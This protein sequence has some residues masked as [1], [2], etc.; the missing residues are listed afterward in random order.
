MHRKQ[1]LHSVFFLC[2]FHTNFYQVNGQNV[3]HS[4]HQQ[5]VQWLVS[6]QGD[7]ELLVQHVPQPAGLEVIVG[8]VCA[9]ISKHK[10]YSCESTQLFFYKKSEG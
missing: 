4:T 3:R 1:L 8:A 7:I 5:V 10:V 6:Q 2:I 9:Y